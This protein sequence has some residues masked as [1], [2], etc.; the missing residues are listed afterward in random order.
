MNNETETYNDAEM[1]TITSDN[2]NVDDNNKTVTYIKHVIKDMEKPNTD[3]INCSWRE[4]GEKKQTITPDKW[5]IRNKKDSKLNIDIPFDLIKDA[6]KYLETNSL[7]LYGSNGY[8]MVLCDKDGQE[9]NTENNDVLSIENDD[10]VTT[11]EIEETLNELGYDVKNKKTL[12]EYLHLSKPKNND[13]MDQLMKYLIDKKNG[14][15]KEKKQKNTNDIARYMSNNVVSTLKIS[16]LLKEDTKIISINNKGNINQ[17]NYIPSLFTL[18][19]GKF[20]GKK[21]IKI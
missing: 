11:E 13:D 21:Y 15:V 4:K 20:C 6:E 7:S 1:I 10:N 12:L 16:K 3:N 2:Q 18:I 8:Y 14:K 17:L 9:V 5:Y 19:V